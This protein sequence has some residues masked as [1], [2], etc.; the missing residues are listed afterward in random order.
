[1]NVA[2]HRGPENDDVGYHRSITTTWIRT[3]PR[4]RVS[5]CCVCTAVRGEPGRETLARLRWSCPQLN[6]FEI[7]V[8]DTLTR[9][10]YR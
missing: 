7:S 5:S 10:G 1:M 4:P 9:N 8:R 6:P 2:V 3:A